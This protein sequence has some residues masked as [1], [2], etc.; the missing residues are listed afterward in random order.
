MGAGFGTS[1]SANVTSGDI[2]D[3]TVVNADISA[4]AL[5]AASKLEALAAGTIIVGDGSG[6]PATL[7]IGTA[8][9]QLRVNAG[10]TALE[11]AAAAAAG[12]ESVTGTALQ[13]ASTGG[14]TPVLSLPAAVTFPGSTITTTTSSH[15]GAM[16]QTTLL[17]A[18]AQ[19]V[20]LSLE[21]TT[22]SDAGAGGTVQ[23]SPALRLYGTARKTN[24]TAASQVNYGLIQLQTLSGAAS[25]SGN[26]AFR[27]STAGGAETLIAQLFGNGSS[28]GLGVNA[29]QGTGTT[30][31][32]FGNNSLTASS[33]NASTA[34]GDS[35]GY[36]NS[37]VTT[38]AFGAYSGYSNSGARSTGVGA[39]SLYGGSSA[40]TF[41]DALGIGYSSSPKAANQAVIGGWD[42]TNGGIT[43]LYIGRNVTNAAPQAVLISITGGVGTDIAGGALNIAGSKGTSAGAPGVVNIQTSTI[44]GT[45]TTLQTLA[46]HLT[47]GGGIITTDV[48]PIYTTN[49]NIILGAAVCGATSN[50]VLGLS[51]AATAPT[52]SVDLAHLYAVD[53]AGA[54]TAA[55]AL[56]QED[57]VRTVVAGASTNSIPVVFNGTTYYLLCTTVRS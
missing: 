20:G 27:L 36:L 52:S 50:N 46:T 42:G 35:A 25:T 17:V 54:G 22:A 40:N 32:A 2:V 48:A 47:I 44:L 49:A 12:V 21:N 23:Y 19:T 7:A 9:Q 57:G 1:K 13:I 55:L 24:A 14:N 6:G 34:M 45:G 29:L 8:L 11:W 18:T 37:G 51:N 31:V 41:A 4:S 43:S 30:N 15:L 28:L 10:A 56:Y 5:I 53:C 38:A 33:G 3:S 16:S 39:Y 26:F